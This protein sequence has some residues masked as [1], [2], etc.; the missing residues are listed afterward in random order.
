MHK[1]T[2]FNAM[3]PRSFPPGQFFTG[4]CEGAE[5][6]AYKNITAASAS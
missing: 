1:C 2:M 3:F 4:W 6:E 5:Y